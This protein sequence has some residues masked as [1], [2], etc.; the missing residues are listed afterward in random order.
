MWA[1]GRVGKDAPTGGRK[2]HGGWSGTCKRGRQGLVGWELLGWVR[3]TV[4]L[5]VDEV[6]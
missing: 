6:N 2:G 4:G 1:S 3:G 5:I